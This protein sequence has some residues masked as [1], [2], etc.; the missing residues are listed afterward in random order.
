MEKYLPGNW[1]G[2]VILSLMFLLLAA[3]QPT[4]IP[5]AFEKDVSVTPSV[6]GAVIEPA[7]TPTATTTAVFIPSQ[8]EDSNIL[9]TP[10]LPTPVPD[11]LRFVF[12]T[13]APPPVSAWRPPL[14]P[15][16][17]APTIYDHFYF[18]RPIAADEINWPSQ[19]YRY[20]GEFFEDVIHTGV[21][22]P[23]P[24]GT[25]VLAAGPGKVVWAGYG[26]YRGGNDPTDPYG[27]AVTIR[28]DFGYQDQP[29]YTVYGH[30]N[31]VD[32]AV[33][34]HVET[35]DQLGLVGK[36]GRVTGPHLHFEVRLGKNDYY[37]TRNPELW[38][39]PPIGWGILA[40]RL[41]DSNGQLVP[42]L[43]L[44]VTSLANN[45]N[46]FG[47]SYGLEAVNSDPYYQENLV[48][49]DLP[50]GTYTLRVAYAGLSFTQEIEIQA[51]LVSY[52]NFYGKGGFELGSP[53]EQESL[54]N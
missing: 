8:K 54:D 37:S 34:Q 38:V 20:G 28:H 10:V 13:P 46:W 15:V 31:Q 27:L 49:G 5:P 52:F 47:R 16:P 11:P 53:P 9:P 29:L 32:V 43:P 40:G 21:D 3:C 18:T 30:L 44:I 22:I 33:G 25:P 14:Y 41:M 48:I 26:V 1:I 4:V 24:E 45:Q 50:A 35:G 12:P 36:T 23:A 7:S 2:R 19:N 39:A 42:Q 17:W 51:G 6:T